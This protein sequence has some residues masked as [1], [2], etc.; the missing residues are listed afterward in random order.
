MDLSTIAAFAGLCKTVIESGK[1][2]ID[3][4][5]SGRERA[6][7]ARA[8]H[9]GMVELV[10]VGGSLAVYAGEQLF[11][12]KD[13]L[14]RARE[15]EAF[16]RLCSRG[17]LNPT[18]AGY[19]ALT[20]TAIESGRDLAKDLKTFDGSRCSLP[21]VPY[22]TPDERT[23]MLAAANAGM[24]NEFQVEPRQ[25]PKKVCVVAGD[26]LCVDERRNGTP[27]MLEMVEAMENLVRRGFMSERIMQHVRSFS[28]TV[29]GLKLNNDL[30]TRQA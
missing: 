6:I 4:E 23:I 8:C 28:P 9:D 5:P 3:E 18:P 2:I 15:L 17:W 29:A 1:A 30:L 7:L 16:Q 11:Q 13:A 21:F 24:P 25:Y 20:A 22:L 26:I 14:E 10:P 19:F 12:G 27:E